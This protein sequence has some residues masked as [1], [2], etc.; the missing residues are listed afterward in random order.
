MKG[1]SGWRT[2]AIKWWTIMVAGE[3]MASGV[4]RQRAK[5]LKKTKAKE[6]SRRNDGAIEAWL[7]MWRKCQPERK[8][9]GRAGSGG[10]FCGER[11][12]AGEAENSR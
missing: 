9:I 8:A 4:D 1:G 10:V 5:K 12:Q 3:I 2:W 11:R 7:V 6:I